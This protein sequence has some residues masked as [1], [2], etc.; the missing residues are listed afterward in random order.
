MDLSCGF[1]SMCKS[2][3]DTLLF[4]MLNSTV[5]GAWNFLSKSCTA[6]E[7][8]AA[9][10]VCKKHLGEPLAMSAATP[11]S[12]LHAEFLADCVFDVCSGGGDEAAAELAAEI[13]QAA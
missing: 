10:E 8:D 4:S 7:K 11:M 12:T 9:A 3:T 1:Q 13:L 6:E 2:V 5:E